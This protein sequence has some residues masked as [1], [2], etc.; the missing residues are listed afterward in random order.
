MTGA[1]NG[2]RIKGHQVLKNGFKTAATKRTVHHVEK[3]EAFFFSQ[4]KRALKY[5]ESKW[6][7]RQ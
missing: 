6:Q 1:S 4:T 3:E 2:G 5:N 7:P